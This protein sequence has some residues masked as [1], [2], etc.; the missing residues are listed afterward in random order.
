MLFLDTA[1]EGGLSHKQRQGACQTSAERVLT[2]P[3]SVPLAVIPYI[4]A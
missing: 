1:V 2:R 3:I 4:T